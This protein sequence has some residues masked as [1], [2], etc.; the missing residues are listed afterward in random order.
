MVT[1]TGSDFGPRSTASTVRFFPREA[2][3]LATDAEILNWEDREIRVL[4]PP[5]SA[6]GAAGIATVVVSNGVGEAGVDFTV[7]ETAPPR[8]DQ[9]IP[10]K[11]LPG[12]TLTIKGV[13]FGGGGTAGRAVTFNNQPVSSVSIRSWSSNEIRLVVPA[14]AVL[15]GPGLKPVKVRTLWGESAE[16]NFT[17]GQL[18]EIDTIIPVTTQTTP[19]DSLVMI[20]GRGFD[21]FEES[22]SRVELRFHDP[23]SGQSVLTPQMEIEET[24]GEKNWT[25]SEIRAFIPGLPFLKVAGEKE[26]VVHTPLGNNVQQPGRLTVTEIGSI[27]SWTRIEPH[28]RTEDLDVGL[29]TGLRAEI[30]DPLWLLG[31]QWVLGELHGEDAGSPVMARLQGESA[32][33]SRWR[34]GA[35]GAAADLPSGVPLETLV[36]HERVFPPREAGSEPFSDRRLAVEAGLQFLRNLAARVEERDQAAVYRRRYVEEYGLA[37][38]TEA[39]RGTL[40][41]ESLRFLEVNAGRVP[42]GAR[43]YTELRVALPEERGGRGELPERPP[44]RGRDRDAVLAAIADWFTWCETLASEP[45]ADETAWEPERMEYAFAVSAETS[46]GEVVLEAPEYFEGRLDW[47]AF[48]RGAGSLR[49]GAFADRPAPKPIDRSLVPAPVSYPGMPAPRWWEIEDAGVNFGSV[50]AGPSDLLRL[51]FVEFAT[52]FGND[53]F[54]IPIDDVPVGSLVRITSLVITDTFGEQTAVEPF[55]ETG[56]GGVWRMFQLPPLDG[57]ATP[58]LL[59]LPPTVAANLESPPL[60]E[61]VFL[62]DEL[63]NMAWAVE[64]TVASATGS[65]L[66][67]HE[68]YEESRRRAE[69]EGEQPTIGAPALAYRLM[70]AVPDYWIPL[71]PRIHRES[72]RL[73]RAAMRRE[74]PDGSLEEI[75]PLGR[76]LE[77]ETENLRIHDEEVPRDG[78]NVTRSWQLA[79]DPSG[80]THLWLGRRKGSGRGEGSSGLR[81][82]IVEPS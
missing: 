60:E 28:A 49:A 32:S 52:V 4:V 64:R 9:L 58:D 1:I 54:T 62:R 72:R 73:D 79:R 35:A 8:I 12:T 34:P 22:V 76:I 18:P 19:P 10:A 11:G 42:D 69:G 63:A 20:L 41:P 39:E 68:V 29:E 7:L 30:A 65:P 37:R 45:L 61:V 13:R 81:F 71:V 55:R 48:V 74:G 36:E 50:D 59:L 6:L 33:L 46:A 23:D 78:S 17:L 38:P 26:V 25:E 56:Q 70:T 43:L 77:P 3:L 40:D 80:R 27:T 44:I 75:L 31:R 57:D 66:R 21:T 82:D 5:I 67:R 24:G 2:G 47:Y 14:S 53:W 51:L 16:Q 15:G